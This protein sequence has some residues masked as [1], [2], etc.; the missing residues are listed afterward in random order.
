MLHYAFNTAFLT[1]MLDAVSGRG[2][3]KALAVPEE[4]YRFKKVGLSL[5][6]S[7]DK[8]T[9]SRGGKEIQLL[10]IAVLKET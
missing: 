3:A 5:T 10:Y 7:S 2:C 9:R 1:A 6:I 8:Q 4:V